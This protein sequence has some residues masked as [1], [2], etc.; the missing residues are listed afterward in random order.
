[1]PSL[2]KGTIRKHMKKFKR[3]IKRRYFLHKM[4][5][6]IKEIR[7]I[8]QYKLSLEH[9]PIFKKSGGQG[10]DLVYLVYQKNQEKP[11]GVIR[12]INHF[13]KYHQDTAKNFFNQPDDMRIQ[14]EYDIY[15][16]GAAQALTVEPLLKGD[17]FLLCGYSDYTP[18][19]DDFI[20]EP[21]SFWRY[22]DFMMPHIGR[23]HAQ[24]IAHC[25]MSFSNVLVQGDK[26]IFIDFEYSY[27]D[28][29]TW[30]E[31]MLYD[32]LN[33]LDNSWK[34]VPQEIRENEAEIEKWFEKIQ[35]VLGNELKAVNVEKLKPSLPRLRK[36]GMFWNRLE[37]ILG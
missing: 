17:D 3:A 13:K 29:I 18:L 10:R 22:V 34:F 11:F 30:P 31:A 2:L 5:P 19:F 21:E 35:T 15:T 20:K 4:T 33:L 37:V 26:A 9:L 23:L 6:R 12:M 16:S 25:D 32:Y 1:M 24:D 36:E 14:Y 7:G 8:I 28:V 27:G